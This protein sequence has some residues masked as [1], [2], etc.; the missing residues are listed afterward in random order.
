[1]SLPTSARLVLLD[2]EGVTTSI[3]FVYDELFPFARREVEG[4]LERYADDPGVRDDVERLREQARRDLREGVEGAVPIPDDDAGPEA[5]RRAA[6]ANVRWQ[7]DADRKTVAL[8]QLQGR[9]W[10]DGYVSGSLRGHVYD[11]VP[12]ALQALHEA[13]LP[14]YVYSSGSVAAQKLLF[15]HS[16]HGDLTG[17]IA[18][19]FD[20]SIGSKKEAASYGAIAEQ[21]GER[22]ED[23]VFVTDDHREMEAATA[24]GMRVVASIR[25]ENPPLPD[26]HGFPEIRTLGEL[27]EALAGAGSGTGT[28]A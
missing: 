1:M 27:A 20:A 16:R 24:A 17:W 6:A 18:G 4:F 21:L 25:P 14:V 22:P 8:K 11:D 28:R 2:V 3:R 5:V 15:G 13:R 12:A 26:G 19:H 7:I 23:V 9:I 10:R